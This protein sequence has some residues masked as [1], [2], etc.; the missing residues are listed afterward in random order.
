M[1]RQGYWVCPLWILI[2]VSVAASEPAFFQPSG[3]ASCD[4]KAWSGVVFG[5][6]TRQDLARQ[7]RISSDKTGWRNAVVLMAPPLDVTRYV[8]VLDG[9]GK[10][11]AVTAMAVV[12]PAP[13]MISP[14]L[15]GATTT[16]PVALY[17]STRNDGSHYEL[18]EDKGILAL[19]AGERESDGVLSVMVSK[20]AFIAPCMSLLSHEAI[21]VTPLVDN[22]AGQARVAVFGSTTASFDLKNATM[23]QGEK[24]KLETNL[25]ELTASGKMQY[26]S[27]AAGSLNGRVSIQWDRARGGTVT[28]KLTLDGEG[29]YG[30]A[31]AEASSFQM[32]PKSDVA[33]QDNAS[34]WYTAAYIEAAAKLGPVVEAALSGQSPPTAAQSRDK[35]WTRLVTAMQ[36]LQEEPG[37]LTFDEKMLQVVVLSDVSSA[38]A[39]TKLTAYIRD[40]DNGGITLKRVLGGLAGGSGTPSNDDLSLRSA[41][42]GALRHNRS[43]PEIS[44]P[45]LLRVLNAKG[46]NIVHREMA[47][48]SIR[49]YQGPDVFPAMQ[50]G[51]RLLPDL[52]KYGYERLAAVGGAHHNKDDIWMADYSMGYFL[53]CAKNGWTIWSTLQVGVEQAIFAGLATGDKDA[54]AFV[55][56]FGDKKR[57]KDFVHRGLKFLNARAAQGQ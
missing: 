10:G 11:A 40:V 19:L 17:D 26:R 23:K 53:K 43:H 41:V 14:E 18:Y 55:Q 25:R 39:V 52:E 37:E 38:E 16:K 8:A 6:T 24:E 22:H 45:A 50:T 48:W 12:Y 46:E 3:F 49:W 30:P 51:F 44:L 34:L 5:Q 4:G 15:A 57:Y 33:I 7:F 27:G 29:P 13:K 35:R 31:H 47:A 1:L 9:G 56:S 28:V 36:V 2:V 54:I 32:L 21:A 20:P 42:L